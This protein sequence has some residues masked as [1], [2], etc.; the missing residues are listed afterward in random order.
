MKSYIKPEVK[1]Y[2]VRI[3]PLLLSG[4]GREGGQIEM[5]FVKKYDSSLFDEEND[6]GDT[7][8]IF[9]LW[10]DEDFED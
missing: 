5:G 1:V 2:K 7:G 8:R 10:D 3:E 4:S 9:C 6:D